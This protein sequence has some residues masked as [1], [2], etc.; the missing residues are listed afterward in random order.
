MKESR[1]RSLGKQESRRRLQENERKMVDGGS[2]G[3]G[4]VVKE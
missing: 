2:E 3:F 1:V 4:A